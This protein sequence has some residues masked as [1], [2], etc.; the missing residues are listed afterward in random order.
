[1]KLLQIYACETLYVFQNVPDL[2]HRRARVISLLDLA[3]ALRQTAAE[4]ARC[5][6]FKCEAGKEGLQTRRTRW[7][8]AWVLL[9]T[10]RE[11][12]RRELVER[13]EDGN[14]DEQ[15]RSSHFCR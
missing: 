7:K 12:V 15:V 5:T 3:T 11:V 1:M 14:G 6:V 2:V 8:N 13:R 9:A 4:R 10:A